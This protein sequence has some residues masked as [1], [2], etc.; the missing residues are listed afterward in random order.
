M[1]RSFPKPTKYTPKNPE[2]YIGDPSNIVCRSSWERKFA[3]WADLHPQVTKWFSEEMCVE[4]WSPVD[5][6]THRYF[7][8]FGMVLSNGKRYVIEIKPYYQCLPPVKGKKRDKTYLAEC[9][10]YATNQAKWHAAKAFFDKQGIE[11]KVLTEK[12]LYGNNKRK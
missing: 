1:A 8:D 3:K 9:A 5:Q 11:F 4:Y 6:K 10:T 12:D 7:P 2:K